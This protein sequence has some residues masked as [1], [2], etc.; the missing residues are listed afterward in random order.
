VLLYHHDLS[1]F[2]RD[3]P[4][5]MTFSIEF[6]TGLL[7]RERI[8]RM[9]SGFTA[10]LSALVNAPSESTVADLPVMDDT[11]AAQ[12]REFENGPHAEQPFGKGLAALFTASAQA[13]SDKVALEDAEGSWT[14]R[15]LA[16][17]ANGIARKLLD[18]GVRPGD[19]VALAMKRGTDA[20][21]ALLGIVMAGAGYVPL[22]PDYPA[23]RKRQIAADAGVR[24]AIADVEGHT[25]LESAPGITILDASDLMDCTSDEP[26]AL[27]WRGDPDHS[28]AYLMYTSGSTGQ[29]KGV[30]IPQRAVVRLVFGDTFAAISSDDCV[31][32]AGPLAF[33]ASTWEV[34]GTLLKGGRLALASRDEILDP[35]ALALALERYRVTALF[36]TTSLFNR[37]VDYD[38]GCFQHV[39]LLLSGGEVMSTAHA[40]RLLQACPSVRL[41]NGYGPT[42]NTSFTTF[43]IVR[44]EDVQQ[45]SIP[46]GRPLAASRVAILDAAGCRV[47]T[48]VWGEI[49]A[50]GLGLADG[51]WGQ[52]ELTRERFIADPKLPSERLYRTG[53]IGRWRADG[54]VEFRGRL[55]TQIK[56][57]GIRIE[58]DEIEQAI[59][60]HPAVARA[61]VRFANEELTACLV[62]HPDAGPLTD[63]AMRTWLGHALPAAM[64][65]TH[66]VTATDIPVNANGKTDRKRLVDVIENASPLCGETAEPPSTEAEHCV[67]EAFSEVLGCPI[68][69]RHASF[70]DLGGHS[71][72][73][74]RV[75]NRIA[76][77]TGVRL[78]MGDFF[79]DSSLEALAQQIERATGACET[80]IPQAPGAVRYPASHAQQ[81]LYLMH[82]MQPDSGAYNIALVFRCD[83]S[84]DAAAFHAA[85]GGLV[86]RHETLR[87][88][89]EEI[90]GAILQ[91]VVPDVVPP[92]EV[93]DLRS[94]PDARAE[95]LRLAHAEVSIPFDLSRAPLIRARIL[96]VSSDEAL[97][98]LLVDHIAA[99]GWSIR[100]LIQELGVL[101]Q[102][103]LA[104]TESGL[105]P[106]AVTYKDYAVWQSAQDWTAAAEFWRKKLSGAPERIAL[107]CT[108]PLPEVQSYRGATCRRRLS[109]EV[110]GGLRELAREQGVT[111]AAVGMAIFAALLYRLTRQPDMVLGMGVAGRDRAELEGQVGFFV[112]VLPIRLELDEE[113][114]L[115]DVIHQTQAVM[116]EALDRRDYPFD[117]LV[118]DVAPRRQTNRQPLINVVFEYQRFGMSEPG[119]DLPLAKQDYTDEDLNALIESPTAK[120]DMILFFRD[121]D[122]DGELILEHDTDILDPDTASRWL[123]FYSSF[124]AE[125]ARGTGK[126]TTQ[127]DSRKEK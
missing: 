90:D 124:A 115:E 112:N 64:V 18:T 44:S 23:E 49:C 14:Y 96:Q 75:V 30:L 27:D 73:A 24:I 97:V 121:E 92:V 113:S 117:L 125:A 114:E 13:C 89:F 61:A 21:A 22:D 116:L 60:R 120:H 109:A 98:L 72:Q 74:I 53:D 105:M 20:I 103:A 93:D 55:D 29:P 47:P 4:G 94:R 79:A 1:I 65:P 62:L 95:A 16:I 63:T 52:P 41:I 118:R 70:L 126:E 107:P 35:S 17:H 25:A 6:Y 19:L 78:R 88:V 87:T 68:N 45:P 42:E 82:R 43:H 101:Y 84:L 67:A 57:R 40:G 85:L 33:D 39:R 38:P 83:G 26:P 54:I 34:W 104:G 32:Q 8:E 127:E 111:L 5:S 51:Y 59:N 108:H 100:I 46:I 50:G 119:S 69:D 36:L 77:R 86:E 28:P 99:D 3:L 76:Q 15:Q 10:L 71:L 7:D 48:G 102:A 37:Q 9:S 56:L 106:L 2:V 58:L 31:L 91:R 122:E 80:H 11:E 66:W 12:V 81:R 110:L 123:D